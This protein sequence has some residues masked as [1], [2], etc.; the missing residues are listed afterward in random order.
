M[1]SASAARGHASGAHSAVGQPARRICGPA[2]VVT[3]GT[4]SILAACALPARISGRQR[5]VFPAA[6][7]R[8]IPTGMSVDSSP[9]PDG[10]MHV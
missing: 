3:H 4:H 9:T 8:H 10:A 7:G 5:S 1:R 2:P 6:D